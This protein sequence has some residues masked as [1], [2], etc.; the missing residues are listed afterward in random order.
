MK[1]HVAFEHRKRMIDISE[2]LVEHRRSQASKFHILSQHAVAR[3]KLCSWSWIRKSRKLTAFQ[4]SIDYTPHHS[5]PFPLWCYTNKWR[6]Q[7]W[8]LRPLDHDGWVTTYSNCILKN[9]RRECRQ[10][11][12]KKPSPRELYEIEYIQP[13][14]GWWRKKNNH[15]WLMGCCMALGDSDN[16]NI[17]KNFPRRI[18][19]YN[20]L[21][22]TAIL[23][24]LLRQR[25]ATSTRP[26][27]SRGSFLLRRG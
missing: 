18:P 5:M 8:Q 23:V 7:G 4:M 17:S 25:L 3:I 1:C 10:P 16:T 6:G 15:G 26:Q 22:G 2:P 20:T 14:P 21:S 11:N 19:H 13:T 27:Q 12:T 24:E 9:D